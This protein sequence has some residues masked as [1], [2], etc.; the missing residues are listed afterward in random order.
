MIDETN[1]QEKNQNIFLARN[2]SDAII[3]IIRHNF[4][5]NRAPKRYANVKAKTMKTF[6]FLDHFEISDTQ[7]P[8]LTTAVVDWYVSSQNKSKFDYM[9]EDDAYENKMEKK[10]FDQFVIYCKKHKLLDMA[11]LVKNFKN[12]LHNKPGKPLWS[13]VKGYVLTD[14]QKV[15][16]EKINILHRL[17]SD[18]SVLFKD[19]QF[20][21]DPDEK[22]R[23][24][25]IKNMI[26]NARSSFD[27]AKDNR[28]ENFKKAGDI[29]LEFIHLMRNKEAYGGAILY[30]P[31]LY[32][33]IFRKLSNVDY[34]KFNKVA[35]SILSYDED[36]NE[37]DDAVIADWAEINVSSEQDFFYIKD[38]SI[39]DIRQFVAYDL[40]D[41]DRL[42]QVIDR[43]QAT[44][45][46]IPVNS[47]SAISVNSSQTTLDIP[48]PDVK[49]PT[50]TEDVILVD[51]TVP[52]QSQQ[53]HPFKRSVSTAMHLSETP[54][55]YT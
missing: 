53:K 4:I 42:S 55:E 22:T 45:L 13:I 28:D 30:L 27:L 33:Y 15:S 51:Q 48:S 2:I 18:L 47:E 31:A 37:F 17:S 40:F 43:S 19:I 25:L 6:H 11:P 52:L 20:D 7:L 3:S 14:S 36:K 29:F 54:S 8:I 39:D 9:F 49:K 1:N 5:N 16:A 32:Q 44:D 24:G 23:H 50:S 12:A 35:D 10:S 38:L 21:G 46:A 26:Y 41:K 34:Y